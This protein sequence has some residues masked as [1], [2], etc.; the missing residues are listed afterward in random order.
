MYRNICSIFSSVVIVYYLIAC[1]IC[2][3]GCS[4]SCIWSV[5]SGC[6]CYIYSNKLIVINIGFL[7]CKVFTKSELSG[8]VKYLRT[9]SCGSA[10]LIKLCCGSV[11]IVV[12]CDISGV[13]T[14][15][16]VSYGNI[17]S[18]RRIVTCITC[19]CCTYQVV[20][21]KGIR[22]CCIRQSEFS[23]SAHCIR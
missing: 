16:L 12:D 13:L 8:T 15:V 9:W 18:C 7:I 5:G 6:S 23:G 17:I 3:C 20:V 10:M 22:C 2:N 21:C 11:Y 1:H 14:S 19:R 4:C